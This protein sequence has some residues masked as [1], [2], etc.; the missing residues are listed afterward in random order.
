[1]L[2]GR[3][4]DLALSDQLLIALA[5]RVYS[6]RLALGSLVL[7]FEANAGVPDGVVRVVAATEPARVRLEG[8]DHVV[9]RDVNLLRR[10][11]EDVL[12]EEALVSIDAD[13]PDLRS[14]WR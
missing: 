7:S 2:G 8:L 12:S 3:R 4:L 9:D 10:A 5:L 14:S 6:S 1:M 13:A 11:G